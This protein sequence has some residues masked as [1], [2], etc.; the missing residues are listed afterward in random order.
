MSGASGVGD[1]EGK[2]TMG[3]MKRDGMYTGSGAVRGGS[4]EGGIKECVL[5]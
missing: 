4:V 1:R 3:N 2:C 5:D